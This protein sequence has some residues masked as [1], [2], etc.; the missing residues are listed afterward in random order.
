MEF[1]LITLKADKSNS[2]II[3]HKADTS[4]EIII[5]STDLGDHTLRDRHRFISDDQ[6]ASEH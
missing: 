5:L 3:G 4:G 1:I 2:Q 6:L